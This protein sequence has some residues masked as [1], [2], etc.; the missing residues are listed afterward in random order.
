[1]ISTLPRT[2]KGSVMTGAFPWSPLP[3][4]PFDLVYL[5]PPWRWKTRTPAGDGRA[6]PYSRVEL[7][8]LANLPLPSILARDSM[9][10]MWVIDTHLKQAMQLAEAW[11]L[12][13]RT[14][15][16]YWAKTNG[17]G[18]R[19]PM[20]TG[21]FTRANP[22]QCLLFRTGKGISVKDHGVPRLIVSPRREHSRK[23]DEARERL[24]LLFGECRRVE[25]FAREYAKGW[26]SW[27]NELPSA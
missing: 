18:D 13:Y 7:L 1:M 16:F 11:R 19:F 26:T 3:A 2:E 20:G 17:A 23:P 14:V 27:G 15:V 12:S 25:L 6:P 22:E 21:K 8:D 5:D 10:A 4:G 24:E 9:V